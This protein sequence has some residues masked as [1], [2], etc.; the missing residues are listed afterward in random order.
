[1]NRNE[2]QLAFLLLIRRMSLA[3]RK[4]L[5]LM[6]VLCTKLNDLFSQIVAPSTS[7]YHDRCCQ[8]RDNRHYQKYYSSA[9]AASFVASRQRSDSM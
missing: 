1:M 2:V 6:P 7:S 5:R 8:S 3:S 9:D 4:P